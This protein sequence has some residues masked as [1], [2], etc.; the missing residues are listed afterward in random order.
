MVIVLGFGYRMLLLKREDK[1]ARIVRLNF[2]FSHDDI[3]EMATYWEGFVG[4]TGE[5]CSGCKKTINAT[6]GGPGWLCVCE[7]YNI[8]VSGNKTIPHENPDLGPKKT[9][10]EAALAEVPT[11]GSP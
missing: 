10:I 4:F 3:V 8:K 5:T 7:T 2:M 6:A 9:V 1:T 11:S